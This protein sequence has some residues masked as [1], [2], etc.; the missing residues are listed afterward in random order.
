M[1]IQKKSMLKGMVVGGMLAGTLPVVANTNDV[2]NYELMGNG[3]ELRSEL[4]SQY[5]FPIDAVSEIEENFIVGETKC[6]EEPK[7]AK[8]TEG[9]KKEAAE[10]KAKTGESK[11]G[12][13]S[14]KSEAK[15]T[16]AKKGKT[17]EAK[18][19]EGKCGEN[20]CGGGK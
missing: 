4:L 2:L 10:S 11:C 7:K 6:G 5:G 12:E 14:K 9:A 15:K 1:K 19:G 8:K 16:E 18:C 17:G 13:E 20:T 3:A